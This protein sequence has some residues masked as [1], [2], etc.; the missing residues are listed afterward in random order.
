MWE[1]GALS[2]LCPS[3]GVT[4]C[5]ALCLQEG[6]FI[7]NCFGHFNQAIFPTFCLLTSELALSSWIPPLQGCVGIILGPDESI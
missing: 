5:S 2:L 6:Y 1:V 3:H 4:L 7:D